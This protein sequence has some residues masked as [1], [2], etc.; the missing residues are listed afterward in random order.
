MISSFMTS[1]CI[2]GQ[3]FYP[4]LSLLAKT[5]FKTALMMI[6]LLLV[7]IA[8]QTLQQTTK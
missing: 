5:F 7:A 1:S 8:H 4:L 2:G 6:E 3:Q